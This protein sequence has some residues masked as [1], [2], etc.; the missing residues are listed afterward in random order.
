M[1]TSLVVDSCVAVKWFIREQDADRAVRLA[2]EDMRL[3]APDVTL[4]EVANAIW[5]NERLGN[6][7]PELANIAVSGLPRYY[8]QVIASAPLLGETLALARQIDHPVYHCVYVVASRRMGV[9]LVTS[10][11]RL[12]AKVAGTSDKDRVI[13]LDNWKP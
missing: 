3:Y 2:Q 10:D 12:V 8:H 9:P 4:V 11:T 7:T 1:T 5:K 13:L 6:L